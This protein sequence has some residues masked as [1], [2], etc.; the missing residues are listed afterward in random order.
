MAELEYLQISVFY[1]QDT[2]T[3]TCTHSKELLS[4]REIFKFKKELT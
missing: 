1:N 3:R 2:G 4:F